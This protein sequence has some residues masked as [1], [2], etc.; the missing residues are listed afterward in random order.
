MILRMW[1][2]CKFRVLSSYTETHSIKGIPE[3]SHPKTPYYFTDNC[4]AQGLEGFTKNLCTEIYRNIQVTVRRSSKLAGTVLPPAGLLLGSCDVCHVHWNT[5][6]NWLK[7]KTEKKSWPVR[8]LPCL[9]SN[10]L[11]LDKNLQNFICSRK[12]R[13]IKK[14]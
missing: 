8:S 3:I 9:P 14:S 11:H 10:L 2:F 5:E 13:K 1:N 6:S 12:F 4:K 7:K